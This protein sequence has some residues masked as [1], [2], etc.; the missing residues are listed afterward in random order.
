V[1]IEASGAISLGTTAGTNRSISAEF[2][3]TAPHSLSEY[4]RDGTYSDGINIP[5]GET[6]I[7][8]SGA[9]SFSN[10]YGTAAAPSESIA[11]SGNIY[12]YDQNSTPT[13]TF[14]VA[15]ANG[16]YWWKVIHGTTDS[17][18]FTGTIAS[19]GT[20]SS[21]ADTFSIT[22]ANNT[23]PDEQYQTFTVATY[24]DSLYTNQIAV[25][26][27]IYITDYR[28]TTS[29]LTPSEGDT[30][31][32]GILGGKPSA[33][34]YWKVIPD[35][36]MTLADTSPDQ[37]GPVTLDSSGNKTSAFT[38]TILDDTDPEGD[39]TFTI[40]LYSDSGYSNLLIE[41]A[42]HT[43]QS[44]DGVT[45]PANQTMNIN[46]PTSPHYLYAGFQLQGTSTLDT[47]WIGYIEGNGASVTEQYSAAWTTG[48]PSDHEYKV[49]LVTDSYSNESTYRNNGS[50]ST[51]W[52]SV[53]SGNSPISWTWLLEDADIVMDVT[54][55][56]TI[57]NKTTTSITDTTDIRVQFDTISI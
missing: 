28:V 20:K 19:S 29:T 47:L 46:D 31:T 9:I 26:N 25:T 5:A 56:L 41:S 18:D 23:P 4:Y 14:N 42:L 48:T 27:T 24:S 52:V 45:L 30:I 38:V 35:S 34:V 57:R 49:E 32:F 39:E 33:T 22:I 55:R 11:P 50:L 3:G 43:I 10:F 12:D 16:Q 53:P 2:G 37:G 1:T 54:V 36:P 21:F 6:G 44:S 13:I 51:S 40:G 8:A 15:G 17:S 7:P